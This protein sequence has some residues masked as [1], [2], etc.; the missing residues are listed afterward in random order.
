VAEIIPY[1][2]GALIGVVLGY[3]VGGWR[4][5]LLP[6]IVAA[7]V[8]GGF[9]SWVSGELDESLAFLAVDMPGCLFASAVAALTV[10]RFA[11]RV[12]AQRRVDR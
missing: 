4:S 6:M 12:P 11:K 2:G 9:A 5:R 10:D 3:R 1:V 8:I 7:V